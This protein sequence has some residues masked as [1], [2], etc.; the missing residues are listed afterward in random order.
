VKGNH[1]ATMHIHEVHDTRTRRTLPGVKLPFLKHDF[2]PDGR[3]RMQCPV[4]D[5]DDKVR[6]A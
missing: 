3:Y 6:E 5:M 4:S 2:T 1:T